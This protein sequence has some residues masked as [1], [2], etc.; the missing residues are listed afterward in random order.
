MRGPLTLPAF[1]LA[2]VC[3]P[4]S[5]ILAERPEPRPVR[6]AYEPLP[7]GAVKPGGWILEQIAN[8]ATHGIAGNFQKYR[9]QY[10]SATWVKKD[11]SAGAAELVGN[12]LEGY[13]RMAYFT[14]NPSAKEKAVGFVRD[15]LGAQEPNGYIGNMPSDMRYKRRSREMFN[16][17]RTGV[18]LL[19]YYEL[20]GDRRAL[21]AVIA[22]AELLMKHYNRENRPF[23]FM[24]G[25]PEFTGASGKM[26]GDADELVDELE[27]AGPKQKRPMINGHGLMYVDV[28][29]WLYRITSDPRYISFAAFLYDD[30]SNSD[31]V[32]PDDIKLRTLLD[33]NA[34]FTG[35]GAHIAEQLRVPMFLA[36]AD[37]RDPYPRAARNAF[38]RLKRYIVP[39]GA[40]V[41]GE[42]VHDL[43]PLPFQGYEYCATTEL[44]A[45]LASA[46]QK[47]GEMQFAD[48]VERLVFNAG[49]GAR[50]PD[51][52][53]IGYVSSSTLPRALE[54]MNLPRPHNSS[55]RWQYSPA[56]QVGGSCCSANAVKL[57][58]AY[59]SSMWMKTGDGKGL[60]ALLLGPSR[61][62]TEIAGV[63]VSIEEKTDYPF[64]DTIDFQVHVAKP[65]RFPLLIRVPSWAGRTSIKAEGAT[66]G[67][68]KG[69]SVIEKVWRGGEVVTV[70]FEHP[71]VTEKCVNGEFAIYRGPLLYSLPWPS[72]KTILEKSRGGVPSFIEW[73]VVPV[74]PADSP[75]YF[76]DLAQPGG[77]FR[78]VLNPKFNPHLPW[79][80]PRILLTGAMYI[81]PD[82]STPGE[83]VL[84]RPI[85]STLL[86]FAAFPPTQ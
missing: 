48:M 47:T 54:K 31:D 9:P 40:L 68:T 70:R 20:S 66:V 24:P 35:H 85:G 69:L 86:R 82:K 34:P 63:P 19:T 18:A 2:C 75:G 71:V 46:M 67:K 6:P 1:L 4:A 12:W 52:R 73:D 25:D 32:A 28:C 78:P 26:P 77:G 60:A 38:D 51:G 14:G 64:A 15:I 11:G 42:G 17:A 81:R 13:L 58:P 3:A 22:G 79:S 39:S 27:P 50:T 56:H 62:R 36:V 8:D 61:V 44:A 41:S 72:T 5:S 55:G 29:E 10:T 74:N 80:E 43:P 21:D 49:Q 84:L 7:L 37:N 45:S 57:M 76:I 33:P 83:A 53:M 59:V 30:Y 23:A 65:V 16:E